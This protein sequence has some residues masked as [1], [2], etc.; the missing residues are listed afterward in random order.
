MSVD[1]FIDFDAAF[2]TSVAK[3]ARTNSCVLEMLEPQLWDRIFSY[4]DWWD[5]AALSKV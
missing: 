3:K 5:R 4:L 2:P 1:G